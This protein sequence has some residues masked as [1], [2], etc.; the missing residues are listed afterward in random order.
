ERRRARRSAL[1]ASAP[2]PATGIAGDRMLYAIRDVLY[3]IPT[4]DQDWR[5]RARA[6]F[7][8]DRAARLMRDATTAAG[9]YRARSCGRSRGTGRRHP[10]ER[11]ARILPA[12][13]AA[14]D[15]ARAAFEASPR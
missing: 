8:G 5:L 14:T 9:A 4:E 2:E 11:A 12:P 1:R 10:A 7:S 13:G 15:E 3:A 6:R